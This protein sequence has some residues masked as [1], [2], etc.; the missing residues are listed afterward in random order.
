MENLIL[1]ALFVMLSARNIIRPKFFTRIIYVMSELLNN[2]RNVMRVRLY[3]YQTE[4][5]Y[6]Y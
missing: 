3:S 1:A 6:I 5:T 4:K 2:V